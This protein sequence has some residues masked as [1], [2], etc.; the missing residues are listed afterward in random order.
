MTFEQ[1]TPFKPFEQ[2]LGVLPAPSSS[3]LPA[4]FK[5]LMESSS[6]PIID[7]YPLSFEVR[8]PL[9]CGLGVWRMTRRACPACA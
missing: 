5:P 1:G 9:R 3:L 8:C 2:L 7:F 4:P 6:S